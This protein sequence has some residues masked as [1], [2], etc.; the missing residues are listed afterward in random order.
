MR[1][2]GRAFG[3]LW[4]RRAAE[5]VILMA[6]T[7]TLFT[8]HPRLT[9]L[10]V[11]A[12]GLIVLALVL[13]LGLRLFGSLNIHYYAGFKTPGLHKYPYGEIPI[14]SHRYPDEEFDLASARRRIGYFG[15]SV[16][17]GVGA[18]YGYRIPDLL[19]RQFP[20]TEHWVY[21][22]VGETLTNMGLVP[23]AQRF[24]LDVVVYLMN[25]NDILPEQGTEGAD[26]WITTANQGMFGRLDGMLRGTSALYTYVRFGVKNALHRSGYEG[27]GVLAYE[28][29]PE[30]NQAML[31]AYVNRVADE[32]GATE[33]LG[34]AQ[35]CVVV[36]PYEMQVSADAARRYRELGFDWEAG[37]ET[38][39]TQRR[40]LAGFERR[41]VRVF[42]AMA[43]F[44]GQ[45]LRVGEAFVY[46][47]GD[48]IDW[49]HPN[50]KG[51]AIIAGWL[52]SNRQFVGA[53]LQPNGKVDAP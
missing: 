21:A 42:D 31:D 8:R 30:R 26:T 35:T 20:E 10:G 3:A 49:N 27:T 6:E 12:S 1:R 39:S 19:Q 44:Q 9:L 17:Y 36:L 16:T 4:P 52:A 51:H 7:S 50:R 15:D 28:R 24:R 13:E 18:G 11:T 40:L 48:K 43:A 38:G 53:C 41:H 25:L 22:N 5:S 37:F 2:K 14:N 32:L 23:Q 45:Q 33:R 46:D 29:F 47:K 34:H